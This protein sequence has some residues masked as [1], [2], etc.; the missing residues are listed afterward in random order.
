VNHGTLKGMLTTQPSRPKRLSRPQTPPPFRLT[1]RDVALVKAVARWRFATSDQLVRYA[2][3][4]DPE[5]SEQNIT[6]RLMALF[7]HRYLDRPANQHIQLQSFS[8]LVYGI[9]RKGAQLLAELGE[10]ID[11]RLK[12]ATKNRRA[13]NAWLFHALGVTE[14]MILFEAACTSRQ[15]IAIADGPALLDHFPETARSLRDPFRLRTTLKDNNKHVSVSVVPDR[16]FSLMLP[17]ERRFNFALELDTGSMSVTGRF[18]RKIEAYHA[19]FREER[20]HLQWGFKG[21]RVATVM[22]SEKRIEHMLSAQRHI[23][24]GRL[25]G[26]FIYTTPQRLNT[27]GP[28]APIW[29]TSER[30]DLAL[31]EGA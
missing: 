7:A 28:F 31:L 26:M 16:L 30:D 24:R 9:G 22:P 29:F 20:H 19:A 12:W 23:T 11:P 6:R 15:D 17:H 18:V 2:R 5:A 10:A 13:S 4:D 25:T 3:I 14:T 21:F 8:H 1:D 27:H